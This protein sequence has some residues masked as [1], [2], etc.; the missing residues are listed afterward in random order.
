MHFAAGLARGE[1][2]L[3]PAALVATN[4]GDYAFLSLKSSA[5]DLSDRGVGGRQVPAALD[6]FV[7][8]ER[9]VYRSGETVHV[10]ALLRDARGI[11]APNVPLTLAI[12][13]P[14]GVDYRRV[15]VNDQGLG[16]RSL[17][18]P[19]VPTA[20][21]GTWR[22]RAYTDP[23]RPPV[24][25]ATFMVE[26]YV[27]DR[28]EFDLTHAGQDSAAQRAGAIE[29]RWQIPLRRGGVEPGA[30]RRCRHCRRCRRVPGF[31]GYAFGL[32]DDEVTAERQELDRS[33]GDRCRRQGDVPGHARQGAADGAAVGSAHHRQ[34]G[35]VR[36]PR[37]GTQADAADCRRMR[38]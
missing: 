2:G 5:F 1:G 15:L 19:I 23:K 26:D 32:A 28:I 4:S 24:G 9:G 25:E 35:G 33:A 31:A 36:R 29:R 7:Y 16:G 27:P 17:S 20:A 37:G 34:H 10:T 38:R 8:T 18:V 22:V 13:R 14:D 6:A 11:A 12:V 21:T 3:S 30:V